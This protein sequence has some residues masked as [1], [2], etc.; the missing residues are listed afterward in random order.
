MNTALNVLL[1]GS[2]NPPRHSQIAARR[3]LRKL[4]SACLLGVPTRIRCARNIERRWD[5][6][7]ANRPKLE[8]RHRKIAGIRGFPEIRMSRCEFE[9][10]PL[11]KNLNLQTCPIGTR[12]V[13]TPWKFTPGITVVGQVVRGLDA[14]CSQIGAPMSVPERWVNRYRLALFD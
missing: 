8:E 10:L 9:K 6:R 2:R 3:K 14:F 1:L 12:F 11:G 5:I 4:V 7:R 13:C